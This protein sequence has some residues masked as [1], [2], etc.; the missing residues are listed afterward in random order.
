MEEKLAALQEAALKEESMRAEFLKTKNDP[1]PLKA[2]C[3]KCGEYG[4]DITV[5]ELLE[6]GDSFCDSMIRSVNGGGVDAPFGV[7]NDFY[8]LFMSALE[9]KG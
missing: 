8:E 7:W 2:F 6:M 1:E 3:A 9:M 4:L 5:G